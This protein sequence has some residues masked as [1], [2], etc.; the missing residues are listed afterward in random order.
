MCFDCTFIVI[1]SALAGEIV[2]NIFT[3][4]LTNEEV[5]KIVGEEK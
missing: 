3:Y 2:K 4:L 5:L 1:R